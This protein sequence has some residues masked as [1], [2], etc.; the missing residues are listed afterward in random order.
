MTLPLQ[1]SCRMCNFRKGM[2]TIDQFRKELE[3]GLEVLE[4]NFTYRMM[5][6]YLRII[7]V[8]GPIKFHFEE[9]L[10]KRK[11]LE[12]FARAEHGDL[13]MVFVGSPV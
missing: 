3:H 5:R 2:L 13:S 7:E 4:R 8:T 1:I 10:E 11:A 9:E 12:A 6:R